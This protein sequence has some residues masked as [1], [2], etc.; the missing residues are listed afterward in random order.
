[1]TFWFLQ[2]CIFVYIYLHLFHFC[3]FL[4]LV[5]WIFVDYCTVNKHLAPKCYC[6]GDSFFCGS[7]DGSSSVCSSPKESLSNGFIRPSTSPDASQQY[8]EYLVMPL[9]LTSGPSLFQVLVKD[10]LREMLEKFVF[11]YLDNI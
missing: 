2:F 7:Q 10:V 5:F 4:H 3:H 11:V 6:S 1:M 9:G 8:Y